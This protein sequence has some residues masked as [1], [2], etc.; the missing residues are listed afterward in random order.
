MVPSGLT[1]TVPW[2]G[3]TTIVGGPRGWPELDVS[4]AR[5]LTVSGTPAWVLRVSPTA[6]TVLGETVIET[7]VRSQTGVGVEVSQ[8]E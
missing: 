3:C 2:V 1:T 8:T 6:V 4:L 7:A 5:T